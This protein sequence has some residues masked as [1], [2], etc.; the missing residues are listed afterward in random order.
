MS[1][2]ERTR[3]AH[4]QLLAVSWN[5]GWPIAAGVVLGYWIDG[6]LGS[7]PAATLVLGLGAMAASTWRLL[8]LSRLEQ[9]ARR[10]DELASPP[11]VEHDKSAKAMPRVWDEETEQW[12]EDESGDDADW[13]REGRD[14]DDDRHGGAR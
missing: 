4:L 3:A 13:T 9:A 11:P 10:A 6:K 12:V 8:A 5:F 1:P 2:S 7:S 14:D